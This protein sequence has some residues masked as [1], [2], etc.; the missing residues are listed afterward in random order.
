MP[1]YGRKRYTHTSRSRSRYARVL[2]HRRIF[3]NRSARSQASQIAALNRR[4]SKVAQVTKPDKKVFADM[5]ATVTLDSGA[6][7][8]VYTAYGDTN[9]Q[10]GPNNSDRIGDKIRAR[11]RYMLSFEYYNNSQTGFHD[12]ESSGV[13]VRII[14]GRLKYPNVNS[15]YPAPSS[16]ISNYGESGENYNHV[17]INPLVSGVTEKNIID[18]DKTFYLTSDRNQKVLKLKTPIFTRRFDDSANTDWSNHSWLV[19]IVGGLHYDNDFKEYVNVTASRKT[20]FTDV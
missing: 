4:I 15:S 8:S 17:T 19:V 18:Y 3:G 11:T 7:G 9:I 1:C 20:V 2:S 12:S 13:Q 16:L 6:T 5:A 10:R 14:M